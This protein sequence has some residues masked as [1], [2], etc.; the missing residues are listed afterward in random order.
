MAECTMVG[1][2][3]SEMV[4]FSVP[5]ESCLG[6]T[7]DLEPR[8]LDFGENCSG[9]RIISSLRF[10]L[11]TPNRTSVTAREQRFFTDPDVSCLLVIFTTRRRFFFRFI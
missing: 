1:V 7:G 11:V 6:M 10:I 3:P 5:V 9:L 8:G 4:V 2:F